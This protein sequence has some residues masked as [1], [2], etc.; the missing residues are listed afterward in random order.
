MPTTPVSFRPP[1]FS[2]AGPQHN[3]RYAQAAAAE[4]DYHLPG[5]GARELEKIFRLENERVLSNDWVVRHENRFYQVERQSQRHAPA[6]SRVTMCKWEEGRKEIHYRGQKLKWKE[7]AARPRSGKLAEAASERETP[8]ATTPRTWK[9]G[10]D[11]PW[12]R[13]YRERNLAGRAQPIPAGAPSSWASASAS[14]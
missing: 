10:P 12:R 5:P 4:A 14:P 13:G 9:P 7:L 1:H 8:R 6:R 2:P 11:Y 3:A